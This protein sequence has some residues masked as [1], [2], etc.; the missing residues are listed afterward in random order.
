MWGVAARMGNCWCMGTCV[1]VEA[2]A[3]AEAAAEEEEAMGAEGGARCGG[4]GELGLRGRL[5]PDVRGAA[6]SFVSAVMGD[7]K[8]SVVEWLQSYSGD[9]GV[10]RGRVGRGVVV[11]EAT[12]GA[13]RGQIIRR[14]GEIIY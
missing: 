12:A 8:L 2:G 11:V 13:I 9:G 10:G 4:W 3:E 6:C 1:V 7:V 14:G 5:V